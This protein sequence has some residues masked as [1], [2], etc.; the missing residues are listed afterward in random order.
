[1]AE[2]LVPRCEDAA[3]NMSKDITTTTI[4]GSE[5][6]VCVCVEWCVCMCRGVRVCVWYADIHPQ[7][8]AQ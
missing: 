8:E 7:V 3:E 4:N 1:M 6:G 2:W 5:S